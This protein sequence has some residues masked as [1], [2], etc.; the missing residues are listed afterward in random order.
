MS[1]PLSPRQVRHLLDELC[2]ELGFCLSPAGRARLTNEPPA[3][4]ETFANAVVRAEGLD[5]E[6]GVP[7]ELSRDILRRV[8]RCFESGA[9]REA[10]DEHPRRAAESVRDAG[11]RDAG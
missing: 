9:E 11:E 1:S 7:R 5:P 4:A 6:G 8:R 10:E 2:T 3:D